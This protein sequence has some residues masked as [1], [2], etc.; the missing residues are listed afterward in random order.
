MVSKCSFP[1]EHH[2]KTLY[3]YN[4]VNGFAIVYRHFLLISISAYFSKPNVRF[5]NRTLG[6]TAIIYHHAS[7]TKQEEPNY[8]I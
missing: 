6:K 3:N 4:C 7:T 2:L 8:I 5:E 1:S